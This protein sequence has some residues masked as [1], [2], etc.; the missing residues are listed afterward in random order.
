MMFKWD[1]TRSFMDAAGRMKRWANQSRNKRRL[2]KKH[3]GKRKAKVL[4]PA[5]VPGSRPNQARRKNPDGQMLKR[6]GRTA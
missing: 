5:N 4:L 1:P 3:R 6:K 2:T